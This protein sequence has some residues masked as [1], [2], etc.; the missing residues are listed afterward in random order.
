MK[1]ILTALL[2][3][4]GTIVIIIGL[5]S[6]YQRVQGVQQPMIF[7]WGAAVV[8]TG[9]ME[10]NVPV[11]TLIIIQEQDAY[12]VGD[13]ITYIDYQNRSI[14]H[15]IIDIQ[16]DMITTQGD[17]NSAADPVFQDVAIIGKMQYMFV[18]VGPVLEFIQQ[19]IIIMLLL[20]LLVLSV[21][22]DAVVTGKKRKEC[23]RAFSI[24]KAK[25]VQTETNAIQSAEPNLTKMFSIHK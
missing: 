3:I 14:T 11:G 23:V 10:P 24:A 13:V 6:V 2:Y 21:I 22:W 12:E 9:S 19:P 17:H 16:D 1:R 5:S 25:S 15:R 20:C 18:G 8:Q 7:G 4:V